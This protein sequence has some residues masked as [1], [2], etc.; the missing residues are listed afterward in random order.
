MRPSWRWLLR[1]RANRVLD[2][3]AGRLKIEVRPFQRTRRQALIDVLVYDARIQEAAE[4]LFGVP[5][6]E[7]RLVAYYA[8]SIA[9]LLS[10]AS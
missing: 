7:R 5:E 2:E 3:V 1:S 4:G 10:P 6:A 9:H 8:N